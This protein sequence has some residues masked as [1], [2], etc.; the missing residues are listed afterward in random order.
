M[1]NEFQYK[2]KEFSSSVS[3]ALLLEIH[4][5]NQEN[6]PEVGSLASIKELQNLVTQSSN[7]YYISLNDTVIAFMICFRE[8][9]NYH[10]DNYKFFSKK[11]NKFLY[12]DRIAIK[13]TYRRKGIAKNLYSIIEMQ[14]NVE[15]I[16]LCCEVNTIPLN[17][18]SIRFHQDFGFSQV[19]ENDFIDHSVAYFQK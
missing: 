6:T 4:A 9:S 12:V 10:S 17:E 2:V 15:S 5:L 11:E 1:R 14:A 18:I 8:R 13:D 16:P 7:N 19:G 3:Q